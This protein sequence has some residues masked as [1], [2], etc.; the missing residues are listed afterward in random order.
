VSHWIS[1]TLFLC[2]IFFKQQFEAA[3]HELEQGK[4]VDMSR[5]PSSGPLE[6][7]ELNR[8][9]NPGVLLL[10]NC[11]EFVKYLLYQQYELRADSLTLELNII[12]SNNS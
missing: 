6:P 9:F 8:K 10:G 4:P 11:F 3:L 12:L 5:L 2:N 7:G 1:R